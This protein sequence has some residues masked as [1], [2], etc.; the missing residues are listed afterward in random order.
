MDRTYYSVHIV[1][2]TNPPNRASQLV[3]TFFKSYFLNTVTGEIARSLLL[4]YSVCV[5]CLITAIFFQISILSINSSFRIIY[6]LVL[7]PFDQYFAR[8]SIKSKNRIF[9]IFSNFKNVIRILKLLN[10]SNSVEIRT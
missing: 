1:L 5:H 9:F 8:Y 3:S 7:Y 4:C 6:I 10:Q 2:R